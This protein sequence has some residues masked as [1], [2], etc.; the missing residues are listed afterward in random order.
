MHIDLWEPKN[1]RFNCLLWK[2]FYVLCSWLSICL[3]LKRGAYSLKILT[4]DLNSCNPKAVSNS[5]KHTEGTSSLSHQ[6][7]C[8]WREKTFVE[9]WQDLI[10][11]HTDCHRS[12]QMP[13]DIA[14]QFLRLICA[15]WFNDILYLNCAQA[16][17]TL[18]WPCIQNVSI[19]S[20]M[21]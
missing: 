13:L 1:S 11:C 21:I 6:E 10:Q 2:A 7:C 18:H 14:E 12:W 9:L 16:H 4:Q 3:F 19:F 20:H 15:E 8:L 5:R 17:S